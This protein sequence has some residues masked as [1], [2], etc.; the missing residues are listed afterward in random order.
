MRG[1]PK[2]I[3]D[4]LTPMLRQYMEIRGRYPEHILFY[5][6]GD[7]YEM[8]F[9]DAKIASKVLNI[10]LTTR[11]RHLEKDIPLAGFPHHHLE[12]YLSKMV[13]AGYKVAVCDQTEDPK[14]AKGVVKRDIVEIVSRGTAISETML[15]KESNNYI[16]SV[17][18]DKEKAEYGFS[19]SDIS[20]GEFS[21]AEFYDF[22]E[23]IET[24]LIHNPAE[25]LISK[26]SVLLN[27]RQFLDKRLNLTKLDDWK[28]D[29]DFTVEQL[30]NYYGKDELEN[31]SILDNIHAIRCAGVLLHYVKENLRSDFRHLSYLKKIESDE[32]VQIDQSTRR[33]LEI[34]EPISM[35]GSKDATLYGVL[36]KTNTGMGARLLKRWLIAPLKSPDKINR[37]LDFVEYFYNNQKESEKL[38]NLLNNI[39][40][41]ERM[42]AKIST[43]RV[44]PAELVRIKKSLEIIPEVVQLLR[45]SEQIVL[46][47]I[48]DNF[49]DTFEVV[50]IIDEAIKEDCPVNVNDGGF[51]KEGY[52]AR[53][54]QLS[55]IIKN[56]KDYILDLQTKLR[57]EL[58]I[59]NLKVGYNRVF[60]YYYEVTKK[61]SDKIP[62]GFIRKQSLANAERFIN[63]ELKELEDKILNADEQIKELE[64]SIL[65]EIREDVALHIEKIKKNAA[66]IG[67]IDVLNTFSRCS[68][69]NGYIRPS[70]NKDYDLIIKNGR[71]PVVE[72]LL[73]Y[74]E[75]FIPNDL[76]LE[77]NGHVH[78]ITGPNMSGKSTF[79]RQTALIVLMA[80]VGCFVPADSA[81]IGVADKIFTR[82]GA[83]DNLAGGQSTFLVEMAESA[84]ILNNA[85]PKSLIVLDEV[86]RGT[87]TFD[88]LSIA[89]AI[90]E[91]IHDNKKLSSR[92]LFATHY[93]ELT[94]MEKI[95]K[96]V[97]N[98]SVSVK[99][100]GDE[101]IFLRKII[102]GGSDN[103]F[104]IHVAKLAGVPNDVLKR[105]N[106]ILS[107]LEQN[108]LTP[109]QKPK[110]AKSRT[111]REYSLNQLSLFE[112]DNDAV[113]KKLKELD[114]NM[115]TPL[116]AINILAELKGML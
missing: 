34:L 58:D 61:N 68:I 25:I 44:T 83:S 86:G 49:A 11:G 36:N 29:R 9:D 93:H 55:D 47:E 2:K 84:N 32:F 54:D 114:I 71:H 45:S 111:K 42:A 97:R 104:G 51:I 107:N 37:R 23:F 3:D 78:I 50:K 12:Q 72:K 13:N 20:T 110:L 64:K 41:V 62:E 57:A 80:Q 75:D 112:P 79:L 65:F 63:E 115:L 46:N 96:R 16:A 31:L 108:E 17:L 101:V 76:N 5:R 38:S 6:L 7:F 30:E 89:W 18:Y 60:G 39:G 90:V 102:E 27:N 43:L 92:T 24:V 40:D 70:L 91:Y 1:K 106:E 99:E 94:E 69:E 4:G 53:L 85:T 66:I 15:D 59:N 56:G 74:G 88:G 48:C 19:V 109:D 22:H 95:C 35:V 100:Y 33:N 52:N 21:Y 81:V 8:F 116:E 10:T 73:D 105:A 77:K 26:E 113:R 28:F 82:V 87:S 67:E 98:Y 14:K 103:S